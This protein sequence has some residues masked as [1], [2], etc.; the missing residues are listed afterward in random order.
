MLYKW[1]GGVRWRYLGGGGGGV[2]SWQ[3]RAMRRVMYLCTFVGIL[4]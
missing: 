1:K 2:Y 4:A 3:I